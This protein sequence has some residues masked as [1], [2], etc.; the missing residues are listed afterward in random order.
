MTSR[1]K[2]DLLDEYAYNYKDLS[3]SKK[4]PEDIKKEQE[5]IT[6]ALYR[7]YL[8]ITEEGN[9]YKVRP[10]KKNYEYVDDNP[11]DPSHARKLRELLE[12]KIKKRAVCKRRR[13]NT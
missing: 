12:S 13:N 6:Y 9:S 11:E 7:D 8:G 2:T 5:K 4:S 10:S 1:T 3:D